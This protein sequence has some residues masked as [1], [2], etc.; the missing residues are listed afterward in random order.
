MSSLQRSHSN[1][2]IL[3]LLTD[4][5]QIIWFHQQ[6]HGTYKTRPFIVTLFICLPQPLILS[7]PA[8]ANYPA[9]NSFMAEYKSACVLCVVCF[10]DF[11]RPWMFNFF[12]HHHPSS[13]TGQNPMP[14][15]IAAIQSQ[16]YY[17]KKIRA[18][19]FFFNLLSWFLNN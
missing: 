4:L 11:L 12:I 8:P 10:L 2:K 5:D 17:N 13:A 7:P 18:S 19:F 15:T 6:Y 9:V 14:Q 1:H 16:C 3:S